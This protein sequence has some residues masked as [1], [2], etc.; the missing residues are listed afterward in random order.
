ML[1]KE[2][3]R[4]IIKKRIAWI[5]AIDEHNLDYD[6]DI[7]LV[8]LGSLLATQIVAYLREDFKFEMPLLNL[9]SLYETNSLTVNGIAEF[10]YNKFYSE[11]SIL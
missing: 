1:Q 9:Y 11:H 6:D 4:N 3:I 10:I 8:G 7:F 2:E 5:L